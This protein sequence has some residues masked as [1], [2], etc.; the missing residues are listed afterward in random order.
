MLFHNNGNNQWING[1]VSSIYTTPVLSEALFGDKPEISLNSKNVDKTIVKHLQTSLV[2]ALSGDP[3]S[4]QN[5]FMLL[6][7][8]GQYGR[9]TIRCVK[10]FQEI[11]GLQVDGIVGPK[12]Y[13]K[14]SLYL[15]QHCEKY[16]NIPFQKLD[17]RN[18]EFVE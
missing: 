18:Y 12:T 13:F 6:D 14:L 7:I 10:R 3:Y 9:R 2:E 1:Y 11:T 8:D 15:L 17:R 4:I 5:D 16:R